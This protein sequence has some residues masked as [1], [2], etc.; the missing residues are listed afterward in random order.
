MS[1]AAI[2]TRPVHIIRPSLAWLVASAAS[3]LTLTL[4]FGLVS[5]LESVTTSLDLLDFLQGLIPASLLF[6]AYIAAFTLIPTLAAA[7]LM[8]AMRWQAIWQ[9]AL[10]GG[11]TGGVM[12]QVFVFTLDTGV[13]GLLASA[14]FGGVGLVGGA[15]YRL[16]AGRS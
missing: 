10:L 13:E 11:L 8:H 3:G 4:S 5:L 16:V 2:A 6:G 15:V 9:A 7:W 12:I 1:P 14:L